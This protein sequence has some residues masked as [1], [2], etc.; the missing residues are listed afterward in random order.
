MYTPPKPL[1]TLPPARG[2]PTG[3]DKGKVVFGGSYVLASGERLEGSLVIFGGSATLQPN[4]R[5]E[6]DVAVVGGEADIAGR[7]DGNLVMVGGSVHLRDG[8]NIRGNLTRTGGALQQDEGAIIHGEQ[9]GGPPVVPPVPPSPWPWFRE[10]RT[11]PVGVFFAWIAEVIAAFVRAVVMAALAMVLVAIWPVPTTRAMKTLA[12]NAPL[13]WVTGLA[14]ALILAVGLPLLIVILVLISVVLT[15]VCIGILGFPLTAVIAVAIVVAYVAACLYGWFVVGALIGQHLVDRLN[16]KNVTL[17][18]AAGVG[19]ALITLLSAV[20]C[21]DVLLIFVVAPAGLGA[22]LLTRFGTQNYAPGVSH[23]RPLPPEL[24]IIPSPGEPPI[25]PVPPVEPPAPEIP[26]PEVEPD[27][28][29]PMVVEEKPL[30]EIG[31]EGPE[32]PGPEEPIAE[33]A[34]VPIEP[35]SPENIEP[36]EPAQPDAP[37]ENA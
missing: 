22:V 21:V 23:R 11:N 19:T 15:F 25:P 12:E 5:V 17:I 27:A 37:S 31:P 36:P 13:S 34:S 26:A 24:P 29:E 30:P 9:S 35:E 33:P 6:G 20:P 7:V 8:A 28:A 2:L 14:S 32:I 3:D 18:T 10:W 16:V 4:S 1:P